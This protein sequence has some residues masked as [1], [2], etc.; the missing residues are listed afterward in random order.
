MN[1]QKAITFFLL[2]GTVTSCSL[3]HKTI[4][5]RTLKEKVEAKDFTI[6]ITHSNPS[7]FLDSYLGNDLDLRFKND[8]AFANLPFFGTR[9]TAPMDQSESGINFEEKMK[10]FLMVQYPV[11]GW[12]LQFKIKTA[13]YKYQLKIMIDKNGKSSVYVTSETRS[14]MTYYGEVQ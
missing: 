3:F 1:L 10:D 7:N 8:S 6:S 9:N 13:Q 12:N 4:D 2:L 14:P 11:S 5:N